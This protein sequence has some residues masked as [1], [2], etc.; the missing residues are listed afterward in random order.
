MRIAAL[1]VG[2]TVIKSGVWSADGISEMR[3]WDT[4]ASLGGARLME[5]MISI[6]DTYSPF[7]A[8]GISTAGQVN[9]GKGC[10][11][12]ANDNIPG[13]TG[14]AVRDILYK[15]FQVPVA[16]ENDAKAA[17]IGEMHHG[18][19]KGLRDFLC[20]TYGTGIGGA[21]VI[22]GKLLDGANFAGGCFGR[23]LTHP[24]K[25]GGSDFYEG[26]YEK[27]A[28]TSALVR[29]VKEK[30][31]ELDDGRKI[32]AAI[33]T[34]GIRQIVDAWIDEIVYGL[35]TLIYIF[36]PADVLLGG[37]VLAQPYVFSE[38]DRKVHAGIVPDAQIVR[39][40]QAVL[41]NLAGLAGASVIAEQL[42]FPAGFRH[43]RHT[44]ALLAES[45][46][47]Q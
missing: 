29:R 32:F 38:I 39:L 9:T 21:A 12:Y 30:A 7:D 14:M 2:G 3:E 34:P 26:C 11:S 46:R 44:I 37:G 31:P 33:E 16:V 40:R 42:L 15:E 47:K 4:N 25:L 20:L 35:V 22:D 13:Y 41:G 43:T 10:I 17:A 1:D 27:Y 5:N 23:I 18:A 6:L 45:G 36:N 24:E 8:I 28:S 19:A